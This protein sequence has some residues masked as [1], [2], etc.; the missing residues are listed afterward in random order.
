MIYRIVNSKKMRVKKALLSCILIISTLVAYSGCATTEIIPMKA[1][2]VEYGSPAVITKIILNNKLS[3]D[4]R[5]TYIRIDRETDPAG[6]FTIIYKDTLKESNNG[7]VYKS[8]WN[9]LRIPERDIYKV[10]MEDQE[11]SVSSAMMIVLGLLVL[12]ALLIGIGISQSGFS[13]K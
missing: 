6:I 12:A 13:F 1:E 9:E 11:V 4:C 2:N 10:Y 5:N 3:I 8:E 7:Y